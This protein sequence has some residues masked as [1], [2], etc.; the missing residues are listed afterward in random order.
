MI[1]KVT[2]WIE[3]GQLSNPEVEKEVLQGMLYD[4]LKESLK[5]SGKDLK[6]LGDNY[7]THTS[8]LRKLLIQLKELEATPVTNT[9][10]L[11]V[12]RTGI[13]KTKST[14]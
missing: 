12:M 3:S 8:K 11:E 6:S 7:W 4:V 13:D 10:V 2:A 5:L 14:T 1:I 9:R